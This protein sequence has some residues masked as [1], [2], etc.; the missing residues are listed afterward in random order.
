MRQVN[1]NKHRKSGIGEIFLEWSGKL[2]LATLCYTADEISYSGIVK[3]YENFGAPRRA[4]DGNENVCFLRF[5]FE[6]RLYCGKLEKN[7][8][9]M[10]LFMSV[11][12]V[13]PMYTVEIRVAS[14]S[15]LDG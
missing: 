4:Q 8:F 7:S 5:D 6:R 15:L 1:D 10:A 9:E 12:V 2:G 14:S 3:C 11:I 13:P